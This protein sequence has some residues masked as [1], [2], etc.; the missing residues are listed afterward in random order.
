[1]CV[2]LPSCSLQELLTA[3]DELAKVKQ[4]ARSDV[5]QLQLEL[6]S[7]ALAPCRFSVCCS[8]SIMHMHP[9][10]HCMEVEQCSGGWVV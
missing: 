3:Q 6:V 8:C 10:V 5:R 1:M 4:A 7:P 9:C 2:C